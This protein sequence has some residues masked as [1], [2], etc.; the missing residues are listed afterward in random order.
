MH[1]DFDMESVR[2]ERRRVERRVNHRVVD[3]TLPELRRIL[4]TTMLSV[5]VLALFVWMVRSVI[6]AA[7]LAVV[8]AYYLRPVHERIA[9]HTRSAPLAAILTLLLLI[10]PVLGVLAYSYVELA[11]VAGYVGTHQ[12]EIAARIDAAVR[13]LPFMQ[14]ANTGETVQRAVLEASNYGTR[15]PMVVRSAMA[16]FGVASAIFLFTAF[17]VFVEGRRTSSWVR[18]KIPPRYDRLVTALET[19]V[20]GVL[21]GAIYSTLL[22]QTVKSVI[23]LILFLA[24]QVPLAAVLSVLSFVIGFF[25]IVGSWSVYL[26]V[27]AWLLV[28]RENAVGALLLAGIG[29]FVNTVFIST[30]LRP[31]L[32]AERS[33]VLDFYWMFVG[34]VCGV[35]TF[36][37]AGILLG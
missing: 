36:G 19:N 26:P 15:I 32:A 33:K 11:D 27:A 37:L 12:A 14:N 25:P 3:L 22:T 10:V 24:F 29:F 30:Y 20:R 28:F 17:Y 31:K 1:S 18:E 16:S 13:R 7:I 6:I 8:I 9:R 35:Y 34:L 4:L 5:V 23:L 2:R 21:S